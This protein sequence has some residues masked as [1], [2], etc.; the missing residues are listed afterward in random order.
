MAARRRE[1]YAPRMPDK[2]MTPAEIEANRRLL[3]YVRAWL[4]IRNMN[5][6]ELAEALHVS[7]PTISKWLKGT[8]AVTVAQF[9]QIA[10]VLELQPEQLLMAPPDADRARRYARI[11]E[12]A[13][14][15]PEDALEE[16]LSLG[17][18][19]SGRNKQD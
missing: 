9:N 12:V 14:S 2:P 3:T 17:K 15:M 16:W 8:V 11:A 18:R 13:R 6:R 1:G 19:L 7:E 4:K 10:T 5:Q